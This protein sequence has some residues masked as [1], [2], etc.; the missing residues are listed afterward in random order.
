MPRTLR[1]KVSKLF[2][3]EGL[4]KSWNRH[5]RHFQEVSLSFKSLLGPF[6]LPSRKSNNEKEMESRIRSQLRTAAK[7]KSPF[8]QGSE[9]SQGPP[10]SRFT[11]SVPSFLSPFFNV[12]YPFFFS[13]VSASASRPTRVLSLYLR[14]THPNNNKTWGIQYNHDRRT[15]GSQQLFIK[16]AIKFL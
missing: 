9:S 15:L 14:L 6:L 5:F 1:K 13:F 4:K 3:G 7:W 8:F 10:S 11:P 2:L 12:F 16:E